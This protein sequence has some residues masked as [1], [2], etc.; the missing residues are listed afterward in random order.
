MQTGWEA[1]NYRRNES[2]MGRH[3]RDYQPRTN[4]NTLLHSFTS[5]A[6]ALSLIAVLREIFADVSFYQGRIDWAK[7]RLKAR[8]V[9]IRAGQNIWVDITFKTNYL[10][11]K[12][13]G[14]LRGVYWFY[15]G[16]ASPG[17][18][19]KTL[20]DLLKAYGLPELGVW[21]DWE[22][23]YKGSH[24]G[25]KNVVAMMQE[26]ERILPGVEIGLYTGYYFY[27]ENS[28]PITNFFQY[29]YLA[30]KKLWLAWYGELASVLIPSIWKGVMT[31]W[32]RG[33]P[34][35]GKEWGV[36]TIEIDI[37]EDMTSEI[38]PNPEPKAGLHIEIRSTA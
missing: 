22:R 24:E 31:Y 4:I 14:F 25:L 29:A 1:M 8:K 35:W 15:D 2:W 23:N 7:M 28:N 21:I 19:A 26:V 33:T 30:R 6:V 12:L 27:I 13:F 5:R 37:N 9:I 10:A 17:E 38:Q 11:A 18:Q 3:L 20:T 34:A 32:Q 16:R 36:E